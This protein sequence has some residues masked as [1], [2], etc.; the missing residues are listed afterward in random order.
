M[1]SSDELLNLTDRDLL[2]SFFS[3]LGKG[4]YTA[5]WAFWSLHYNTS[6]GFRV[7]C[8]G[9]TSFCWE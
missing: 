2:L 3:T 7:S 4:C 9:L 6:Q 8:A 5:Y 1:P